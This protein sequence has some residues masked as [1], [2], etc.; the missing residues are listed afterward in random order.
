MNEYII[1]TDKIIEN[2]IQKRKDEN[3]SAYGLSEKIGKTKF[4][5]PNIENRK[6]KKIKYDDLEKIAVGLQCKI[7]NLIENQDMIMVNEEFNYKT[8]L[9]ENN[10][11]RKENEE[12]KKKI[13]Y[14]KEI[15]KQEI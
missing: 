7:E 8:L 5:L 14:I 1:L 6:Q 11:L 15:L 3:L 13:S 2:I 9:R 4:W 10:K 12:L